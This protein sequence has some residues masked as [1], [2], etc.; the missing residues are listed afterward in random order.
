[1]EDSQRHHS[2]K[3]TGR[4]SSS[5]PTTDMEHIRNHRAGDTKVASWLTLLSSSKPLIPSFL[6]FSDQE[7]NKELEIQADYEFMQQ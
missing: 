5:P 4:T 3:A 1:M 2:E 6:T 7:R